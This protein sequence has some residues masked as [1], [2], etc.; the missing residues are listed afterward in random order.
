MTSRGA[1]WG[2]AAGLAGVIVGFA[3]GHAT[4]PSTVVNAVSAATPV[5]FR[6]VAGLQGPGGLPAGKAVA[7]PGGGIIT[8]PSGNSVLMPGGPLQVPAKFFSPYG[9]PQCGPIAIP[10]ARVRVFGPGGVRRIVLHLQAK[11]PGPFSV[12]IGKLPGPVVNWVGVAGGGPGCGF[13]PGAM[14]PYHAYCGPFGAPLPPSV[15]RRGIVVFPGK[16]P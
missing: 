3:I 14:V 10:G 15:F 13:G 16:Q 9:A 1:G 6:H 12:P 8:M 5:P 2:V 4:A 7:L 11:P